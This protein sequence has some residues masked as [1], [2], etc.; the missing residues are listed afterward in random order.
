[1]GMNAGCLIQ[2][3]R[4]IDFRNLSA[5]AEAITGEIPPEALLEPGDASLVLDGREFAGNVTAIEG[6][7]VTF[8]PAESGQVPPLLEDEEI[9]AL[10]DDEPIAQMVKRGREMGF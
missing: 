10:D 1:M 3:A 5:A 6:Q 7:K 8:R 4:K 2:G 9:G